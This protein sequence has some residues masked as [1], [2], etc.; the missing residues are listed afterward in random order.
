M[1]KPINVFHNQ[2]IKWENEGKLYCLHVQVDENPDDP[3]HEYGDQITTMACWH[4]RYTLGDYELTKGQEPV[5]FWHRLVRD[6]VPESEIIAAACEGKLPG[7]RI[8]SCEN[9]NLVNVYETYQMRSVFGSSIPSESLEYE[10]IS[11][12]SIAAYI[13][14]DLSVAHC[15]TL[16]EP[17]AEWLPLW[18]YDHSGISISCGER[19]GQYADVWDSGQVGWIIVLKKDVIND[20]SEYVLDENGN[21]ITVEHKH[22]GAPSTWGYL[23]KPLTEETWRKRAVEHMEE[24][25]RIYDQYL[26]GDIY[27][28]TLYSADPV[29]DDE[30]PDWTEEDSCGGFFGSDIRA[31]G[32]ADTVGCGLNKALDSGAYVEDEAE[33]HVSVYYSF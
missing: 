2:T 29:G 8:V 21:R 20:L 25:V 9:P 28:Y 5:D 33:R 32:M 1:N 7:I 26:T 19:R 18:L 4:K 24:D 16:M 3:R 23:T 15:M 30:D 14:D 22:E 10:E 13:M 6:N 12:D 11:Q 17:Y 27:V 31:S